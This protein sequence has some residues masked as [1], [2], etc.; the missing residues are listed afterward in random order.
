MEHIIGVV[1]VGQ[2]VLLF[3]VEASCAGTQLS[4]RFPVPAG[5]APLCSQYFVQELLIWTVPHATAAI[6]VLWWTSHGTIQHLQAKPPSA[7]VRCVM[8]SIHAVPNEH[9]SE[10]CAPS[11]EGAHAR[12]IVKLTRESAVM[13]CVAGARR[14]NFGWLHGQ[15]APHCNVCC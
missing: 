15:V 11:W 6:A 9:R 4:V 7:P 2:Y 13:A 10:V 14:I 1:N 12:A 5:G 3:V 8:Y